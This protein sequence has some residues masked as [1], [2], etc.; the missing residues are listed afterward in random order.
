M[1]T[2]VLKT[3]KNQHPSGTIKNPMVEFVCAPSRGTKL[4][5]GM[6]EGLI[7]IAKLNKV[8]RLLVVFEHD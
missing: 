5:K 3:A 7:G 1:K 6:L 4:P 8:R 2:V